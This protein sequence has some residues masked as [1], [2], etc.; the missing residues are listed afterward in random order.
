MGVYFAEEYRQFEKEMLERK[1][2]YLES[3]C[4]EQDFLEYYTMRRKQLNRDLAY[5]RRT[6]S[7]DH[8]TE[9]MDSDGQ[10]PL[11]SDYLS[12]L[13]VEME[14]PSVHKFWWIDQIENPGLLTTLLSFSDE[15]LTL[16]DMSVYRGLTQKAIAKRT[17][18]DQSSISRKL[19]TLYK[20]LKKSL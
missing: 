17:G 1:K 19:E 9:D 4:S 11:Y 15:E 3:G 5:R 20:K 16:I 8:Q 2:E 18:K 6:V 13:S 12:A 14:L 10:N 7:L